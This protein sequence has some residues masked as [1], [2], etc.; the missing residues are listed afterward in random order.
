M[1]IVTYCK[2]L[3]LEECQEI[4]FDYDKAMIRFF[5]GG[6]VEEL[7]FRTTD[8]ALQFMH[9][10]IECIY[11][12]SPVADLSYITAIPGTLYV[13]PFKDEVKER[14]RNSNPSDNEDNK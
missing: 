13:I 12:G 6:F 4:G 14:I 2:T 7:Y 8:T 9:E 10:L 1:K 11:C 3:D 5:L